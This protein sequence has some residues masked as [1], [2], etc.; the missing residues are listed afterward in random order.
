MTVSLLT[1]NF[2]KCCYR[3]RA[4]SPFQLSPSRESKRKTS[5]PRKKKKKKKKKEMLTRRQEAI[6]FFPHWIFSTR[7]KGGTARGLV[8]LLPVTL[9]KILCLVWNFHTGFNS[10]SSLKSNI[11]Q[12]K[13]IF[14]KEFLI[15]TLTERQSI[16]YSIRFAHIF[17]HETESSARF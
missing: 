7:W 12:Q 6:T 17:R 15:K 5:E 13:P 3:L 14:S 16:W 8:L 2:S 1:V 11:K 4:V 10:L 9:N